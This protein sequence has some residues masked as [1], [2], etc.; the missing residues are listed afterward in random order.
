VADD[1][2]EG[3]APMVDLVA[4][5]SAAGGGAGE[6]CGEGEGDGEGLTTW[7]KTPEDAVA[8]NKKATRPGEEMRILKKCFCY[9][10]IFA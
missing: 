8:A 7:A 10:L 5:V 6:A 2:G 3:F 9:A 1:A 4:E